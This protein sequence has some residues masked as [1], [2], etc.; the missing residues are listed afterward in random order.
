M[1]PITR[2]TAIKGGMGAALLLAFS[3]LAQP[4][5]AAV[6]NRVRLTKGRSYASA[7]T[8]MAMT[9]PAPVAGNLL[10]AVVGVDKKAG[11]F[12][13]PPGWTVAFQQAGAS[14]S[15]AAVYRVAT[16]DETS[17]TIR[18][19]TAC[20][21]GSWLVAEYTGINPRDPLGPVR[22]ATY[23]DTARTSMGLDPATA[24]AS[25]IALAV[26]A[27]DSMNSTAS[28]E[29]G[30][31]EFRPSATGW[32]WID[33][34][35]DGR[36]GGC[37]ARRSPSTG[38]RWPPRP[39]LRRRPSGGRARTRWPGRRS[40]STPA[41]SLRRP[42]PPRSSAG[43]WAASPRAERSSR[44]R[45]RRPPRSGSRSRPTLLSPPAS[46][47][48]PLRRRTPT[49]WSGSP[50]TACVPARSTTSRWRPTAW[51]TRRRPAASAPPRRARVT[52]PS[53]SPPAATPRRR[54]RSPRSAAATRTCS[55]TWAT[56]TTATSAERPGGLPSPVRHRPGVGAPGSPVRHRAHDLHLVG[57]RLRSERVQR[58]LGLEAG[59]P[60]RL[61]AVR[62]LAH[63]ALTQRRDLPLLRLRQGPVR[64][65]GQPVLQVEAV[66]HGRRRQ[67]RARRR[68][69]AVVQERDQHGDGA[70]DHLGQ[71]AAVDRVGV[72]RGRPLG[73]L[74]HRARRARPAHHRQRQEGRHHLRGHARP[75]RGRRQELAGGDPGVP[76]RRPAP[77][78]VPQGWAVHRGSLPLGSRGAGRAVRPDARAR[79]RARRSR[80]SSPGTTSAALRDSASP[81]RSPSSPG[82]HG[83]RPPRACESTERRSRPAKAGLVEGPAA[84]DR[85]A[86]F[87]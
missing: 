45:C 70:G 84:A 86:P 67:D 20:A 6:S 58:G 74:P 3:S 65:H 75:R 71:R 14:V 85:G 38:R 69:E 25:S 60:G 80:C 68:A 24:E 30:G 35:Y 53:R 73:R 27:V 79:T 13:A 82:F 23:S 81:R 50:P 66:G 76:R 28:G 37:P 72:L 46:P 87:R 8:S 40:C 5:T 34:S 17:A 11:S 36:Q 18:W 47:T 22:V 51:W 64:R 31:G 21:G 7:L 59:G 33:T 83:L 12:T 39:T 44:R 29:T 61:P 48:R 16:G 77:D 57:P 62:A 63:A 15:L 2:R 54:T 32:N 1:L 19:S 4:A 52:S 78:V 43:G 49:A 9:F 10:L 56:C 41:T 55:S 42:P 26:F